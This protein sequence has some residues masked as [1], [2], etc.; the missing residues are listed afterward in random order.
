MFPTKADFFAQPS[1]NADEVSAAL[2]GLREVVR[3]C[4]PPRDA[5][6]VTLLWQELVKVV[7]D[8]PAGLGDAGGPLWAAVLAALSDRGWSV[9]YE[10]SSD[11]F[12]GDTVHLE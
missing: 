4:Q 2:D 12:G 10:A 3:R 8:C 7:P 6:R 11:P 1:P 9:R 5:Q